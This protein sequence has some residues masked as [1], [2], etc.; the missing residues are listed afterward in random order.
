MSSATSKNSRELLIEEIVT[1][2]Y[3]YPAVIPISEQTIVISIF[4]IPKFEMLNLPIEVE[5]K[6]HFRLDII[7]KSEQNN[8]EVT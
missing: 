4:L 3:S 1:L 2:N 7:S 8:L 5:I 6:G